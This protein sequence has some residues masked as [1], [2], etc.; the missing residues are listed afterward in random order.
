M[1]FDVA[2]IGDGHL[3]TAVVFDEAILSPVNFTESSL[4]K[5]QFLFK[6]R[7]PSQGEILLQ[8]EDLEL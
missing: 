3:V 6:N 7:L 1:P 4:L 2:F 5:F 8:N